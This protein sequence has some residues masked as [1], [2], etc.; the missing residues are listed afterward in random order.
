MI[1]INHTNGRLKTFLWPEYSALKYTQK[2][3]SEAMPMYCQ[4]ELMN[5][6]STV[7][8]PASKIEARLQMLKEIR[9][10]EKNRLPGVDRRQRT[11]AAEMSVRTAATAKMNE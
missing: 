7:K 11:A 3:E 6:P 8:A 10:K 1:Q 2:G 4:T 5:F 9:L